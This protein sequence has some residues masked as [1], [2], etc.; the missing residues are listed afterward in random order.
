MSQQPLRDRAF[1]NPPA[2]PVVPPPLSLDK[3]IPVP[4]DVDDY[5]IKDGSEDFDNDEDDD[6]DDDRD[7]DH[8]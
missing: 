1:R 8:S 5:N 4:M 6:G 2:N 7:H 3:V